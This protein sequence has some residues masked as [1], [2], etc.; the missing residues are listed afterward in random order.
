MWPLAIWDWLCAPL[1]GAA[2]HHIAQPLAWHARLMVLSWGVLLPLGGLA[3]R[4][5]KITPHQSW[6]YELDNKAWWHAHRVLQ[7]GGVVLMS[8]GTAL[9][10]WASQDSNNLVLLVHQ[11]LGWSLVAAGWVQVLGGWFRGSKGGPQDI[12]LRGDHYDMTPRR[13]AFERVHK[14][15]G[16]IALLLVI[17]TTGLGLYGVDAPRWM[18]LVLP[19]WWTVLLVLFV[20]WQR[21]GR[22]WDTYQAIWGPD[23]R[24]PGNRL[25]PIGWGVRRVGAPTGTPPYTSK[26]F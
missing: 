23:P 8:L 15:L 25:K 10:V 18:A 13:V 20:R 3:A 7:I 4:F 9:A 22:C 6:P 17:P 16:W 26:K 2:D 19:L 5:F 24:H 1:S 14:G 11:W 12:N 21:Q